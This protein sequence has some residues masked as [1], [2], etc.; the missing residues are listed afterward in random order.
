[1]MNINNHQ[2]NAGARVLSQESIVFCPGCED[3]GMDPGQNCGTKTTPETPD[4][5]MVN[6]GKNSGKPM[7]V[8]R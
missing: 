5:L 7:Q 3:R 8:E 4:F 6:Y 2:T 1:M